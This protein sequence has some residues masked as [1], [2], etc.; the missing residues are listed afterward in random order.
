MRDIE[1]R[2]LANPDA[3]SILRTF[4]FDFVEGLLIADYKQLKTSNNPYRYRRQ[5]SALAAELLHDTAWRAKL[6][7]A[8]IEQGVLA[9]GTSPDAAEVKVALELEKIRQVFD[10]VGPFMDRIEDFRDR[11]ERRVRTT[12]HY[13]DVMGEGSAERIARI[14]ERLAALQ[15]PEAE[16]RLR[17]P[18]VGFPVSEKALY[19]PQ[20]PRPT[21]EKTR[22]RLPGRDHYLREYVAATTAFD[23]MVRVTPA[24][25]IHF[26][27][28][29][30]GERAGLHSSEIAVESIEDFLA[31]RSLPSLVG[32][33]A[34]AEIGLYRVVRGHDRTENEWI[35]L[36]S[37]RI[38]R[39]ENEAN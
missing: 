18:D 28:A 39:R 5:I 37:F 4:F 12:V 31:F 35:N 7:R 26:I 23:R 15:V 13:M 34:A 36:Q 3:A 17:A 21:P 9:T 27:E 38:E 16:W 30:L 29:K 22:F 24:K 10:D 19:T 14:I 11:L 25:M 32:A 6:A 1:D 20:P 2:I 8:Y 33:S